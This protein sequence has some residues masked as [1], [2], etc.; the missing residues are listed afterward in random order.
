MGLTIR[1]ALQEQGIYVDSPCDGQGVCGQ[2]KIRV[3][4]A[5]AVPETLHANIST[6][7]A[8][9]GIRLACQAIPEDD[10]QVFLP[11][12]YR[13]DAQ[14]APVDETI[15]INK[16]RAEGNIQPAV[17]VREADGRFWFSHTLTPSQ[18]YPLQDWTF[19]ESPKG[20]A[21]DL[22]TT[23]LAASLVCL[24]TGRELASAGRLNPQIDYG[25]DVLTRIHRASDPEGLDLLA[26]S[27][28]S[29]IQEL[30]RKICIQAGVRPEHI[31]DA[32]IGGNTTMLQICAR[33]DP[34][35]L[36][37]LPFTVG[38]ASG[39][40]YPAARFGLNVHPQ[41]KVYIPP[42]AHAFVG[43]DIS[44]GLV[45]IQGFFETADTM[46]FLDVGTNGEM[47]VS[48]GNVRVLTSTAAGPAFEGSGLRS[49]MRA[50][51]GA[52]QAVS[53]DGNDLQ[54]QIIGPKD[55]DAHGI[56]GSGLLD[57]VHTLLETGVLDPS[58]RLLTRE[59]LLDL[60]QAVVSRVQ[61]LDGKAA[62]QLT[63]SVW[64]TQGDIRQLQLAKGAVRTGI[65][66]LLHKAGLDSRDLQRV[67]VGGGFGNVL[68]PASLEGV[69]MLPPGTGEKVLFA[70]NTSQLGCVRL[71]LST[72]VRKKL[73]Q[74]MAGVE[75]IG[76]AQDA[77]F[78]DAFVQNM[79][80]PEPESLS[81]EP[82][83]IGGEPETP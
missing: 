77:A 52:I 74:D 61:K 58:G 44:A 19:K 17:Q 45:A 8:Q 32:V 66:F 69:G 76:L 56:C 1:Q 40:S 64:L 5:E 82:S 73:E 25:H 23:T 28:Q 55:Q 46:L 67:V 62:L 80:F 50:A 15:L 26:S 43:S 70:G 14:Q 36:G 7:E 49:G 59:E 53:Y 34:S 6:E 78:M 9:A 2:C 30:I 57:L 38:L 22:G 24:S 79:V 31:L 63:D 54:L 39:C 68:R 65:D 21:L 51:P 75:H 18:E 12:T 41:A 35:P 20:L 11:P 71:L 27:V 4:P 16:Y 83:S 42:I 81:F 72:A 47:G 29:G 37:Q 60:P 10:I 33:E 48:T 3:E 13:L